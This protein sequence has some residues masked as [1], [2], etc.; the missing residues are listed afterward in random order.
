M[1]RRFH[2]QVANGAILD[3]GNWEKCRSRSERRTL[4]H[5]VGTSALGRNLSSIRLREDLTENTPE[6]YLN[7]THR[8]A[9]LA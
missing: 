8:S 2:G 3:R 5:R 9:I 4:I 6:A 7:S 1:G